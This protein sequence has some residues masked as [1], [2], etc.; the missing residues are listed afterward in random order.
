MPRGLR[1]ERQNTPWKPVHDLAALGLPFTNR[2]VRPFA[3]DG[4]HPAL[5]S[6]ARRQSSLKSWPHPGAP[7]HAGR[8]QS[9]EPWPHPRASCA[10]RPPISV[11]H[12]RHSGVGSWMHCRSTTA[13]EHAAVYLQNRM[14]LFKMLDYTL[15]PCCPRSVQRLAT[16]CYV[17]ISQRLECAC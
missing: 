14:R 1:A 9:S 12:S 7:G 3:P 11:R 15:L 8:H 2:H 4:H 13:R 5:P 6:Y 10:C 16:L 17:V